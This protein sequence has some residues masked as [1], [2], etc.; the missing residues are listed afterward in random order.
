MYLGD[1]KLA[2]WF[3]LKNLFQGAV[4]LA[5]NPFKTPLQHLKKHVQVFTKPKV[6]AQDLPPE[7]V[8]PPLPPVWVPPPSSPSQRIPDQSSGGLGPQPTF[9]GQFVAQQR[10]QAGADLGPQG[11]S[12]NLPAMG[13]IPLWVW[14]AG[15]GVGLLGLYLVTRKK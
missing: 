2:G 3:N 8:A 5:K 15:A 1:D 7:W 10:A 13:G 9:Q 6:A 14:G 12:G 4:D 11:Y